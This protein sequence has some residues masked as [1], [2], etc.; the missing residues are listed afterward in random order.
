MSTKRYKITICKGEPEEEVMYADLTVTEYEKIKLDLE[1]SLNSEHT[2][3]TVNGEKI[4]TGIIDYIEEDV[5]TMS[6][7]G[8]MAYWDAIDDLATEYVEQLIGFSTKSVKNGDDFVL[9]D[10]DDSLTYISKRIT[11]FATNLLESEYGA[12]FPYVD[13]NY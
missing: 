7:K 1:G 3:L 9:N 6:K 12:E 2:I 4:E 11:E 8:N 5:C 10:D 13:E